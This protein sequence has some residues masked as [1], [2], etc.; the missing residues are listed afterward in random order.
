VKLNSAVAVWGYM[1]VVVAVAVALLLPL[2][3]SAPS[4]ALPGLIVIA[5]I[6]GWLGFRWLEKGPSIK[7]AEAIMMVG[8]TVMSVSPHAAIGSWPH[9]LS[10][11]GLSIALIGGGAH[12]VSDWL[13]KRR[14][15]ATRAP[16]SNPRVA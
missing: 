12:I 9:F 7:P 2:P 1:G 6:V 3:T 10:D 14:Q 5:L 4:G 13:E 8:I 15:D 11:L 16:K